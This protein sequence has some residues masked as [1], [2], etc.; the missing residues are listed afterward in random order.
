VGYGGRIWGAICLG[1][2]AVLIGAVAIAAIGDDGVATQTGPGATLQPMAAAPTA[3]ADGGDAPLD[4]APGRLADDPAGRS[5]PTGAA[6][7]TGTEGGAGQAP[8]TV[9][10]GGTD[11]GGPLVVAVGTEAPAGGSGAGSSATSTVAP[12]GT[13]P[14]SAAT[15]SA[16]PATAVRTTAVATTATPTTATP[17]TA[18]P[19]TARPTTAPPTAVAAPTA[20]RQTT[21]TAPATTSTTAR[22]TTAAPTTAAPATA[23]PTTAAPSGGGQSGDRDLERRVIELTNRHRQDNGCPPLTPNDKLHAS[24]L[25]HSV[26]MAT[27]NYFSHTSLDGS[28]MRDRIERQ[29][30]AW[31]MLAEN[32]AAGYRTPESVV[33]GWM[34]S[35]GHRANILNCG[36]TEIGVGHH[37]RYWT[38]NFG[39]RR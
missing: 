7:A 9:A 3:A 2:L 26:D 38:Q 14:T 27:R 18:R 1:A 5:V 34:N 37:Q 10:G 25:G 16:P 11:G 31:R 12:S 32:I 23:A 21:A 33:E 8:A 22:P 6:G 24:A 17:T 4:R 35:P 28:S 36:L 29:G 13:T 19:T 20:A 15:S 30:Y 39:T